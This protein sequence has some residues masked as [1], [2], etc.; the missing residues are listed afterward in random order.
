M[1]PIKE[2]SPVEI[3]I[4]MRTPMCKKKGCVVDN[5]C[6]SCFASKIKYATPLI[7]DMCNIVAE[8]CKDIKIWIWS[9]VP[10]YTDYYPRDLPYSA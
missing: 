1:N 9:Q 10:R 7:M 2:I 3:K 8:Y 6:V 5:L 4:F